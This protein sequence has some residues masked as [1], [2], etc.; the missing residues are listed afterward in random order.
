M[1]VYKNSPKFMINQFINRVLAIIVVYNKNLK[2]SDSLKSIGSQIPTNHKLDL[3]IYDN[4]PQPQLVHSFEGIN[5]IQYVHNSSNVGV[6]KAYND[7]A[8]LAKQLQKEWIL[9]LDQDTLFQDDLIQNYFQAVNDNTQINLFCPIIMLKNNKIFSPFR[10]VLKRGAVMKEISSKPY[11]I[12]N[13][14]PVNSGMLI[15]V[16]NFFEVGGY[17]EKVRL[18]FSDLQFIEKFEKKNKWFFVINSFALQD[19]SNEEVDVLKLNTRFEFFCE[20]VL[21]CHKS[22]LLDD[23][24][25]F[26]VVFIRATSLFIR[27]K[28]TI[29]YK[30]F[31]YHYVLRNL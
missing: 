24:K 10:R 29:F 28:R 23:L 18:D 12:K 14:S 3:I 31:F 11:A 22:S 9:L 19:F 1:S 6:S 2:D 13:F 17:N 15:R 5:I 16:F 20:G 8:E 7:G 26:L 30:T 27:T 4:S 21:N 25:F